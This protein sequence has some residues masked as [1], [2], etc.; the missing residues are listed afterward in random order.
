MLPV[1]WIPFVEPLNAL[2]SVWLLLSIPLVIGISMAHKA[3]RIPEHASWG[4]PSAIMTVQALLGI[5]A[6][7]VVLDL[8]VLWVIP[9]I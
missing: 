1:A 9:A 3:M 8:F 6:L 4:R 5:I 7:A 2:Q